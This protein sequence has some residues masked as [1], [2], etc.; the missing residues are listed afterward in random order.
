VVR[1]T[2]DGG[3]VTTVATN[4]GKYPGFVAYDGLGN[5]YVEDIQSRTLSRVAV[6]TGSVTQLDAGADG[7]AEGAGVLYLIQGTNVVSWNPTTGATS[8]VASG[9]I[10]PY[11]LAFDGNQGL[12]VSDDGDAT[13]RLIDLDGGSVSLV[14]GTPF[15]EGVTPGPLP[16]VLNQPSGIAVGKAGTLFIADETENAVL[17]VR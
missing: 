17:E 12:Y 16:A 9:F 3:A 10:D 13:V 1:V 6:A 14:V 7:L 5:L 15:N 11:A 4:V 8:P 2:L